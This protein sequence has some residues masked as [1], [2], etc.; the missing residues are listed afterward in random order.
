MLGDGRVVAPGSTGGAGRV[1][2]M[3]AFLDD[4]IYGLVRHVRGARFKRD[5]EKRNAAILA[6]WRVLHFT[7]RHIRSGTAVREIERLMR[8]TT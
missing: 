4:G 5:V 1:A 3:S 6:G 2:A 8:T 7:P